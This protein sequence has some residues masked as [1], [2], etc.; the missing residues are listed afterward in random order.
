MKN[1]ERPCD[2][3]NCRDYSAPVRRRGN[4]VSGVSVGE[5]H[6]PEGGGRDEQGGQGVTDVP[7]GYT[8]RLRGGIMRLEKNDPHRDKR[9]YFGRCLT[10][11]KQTKAHPWKH[12]P[13]I[14]AK[15]KKT[16]LT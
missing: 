10:G 16:N 9:D 14:K 2:D 5:I 6:R 13:E 12:K 11:H 4:R 7:E 15:R 3:Y 8:R 1:G